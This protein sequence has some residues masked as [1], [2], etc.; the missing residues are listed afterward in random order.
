MESVSVNFI[1]YWRFKDYPHL[2]I[3]KCKKIINSITCKILV[4]HTKGFYIGNRYIKRKD[5]R[6]MIE[7]I[8]K[9]DRLP[10]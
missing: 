2:K 5:L 6:D 7:P 8:P 3:T 1:V 9:E 4:Y 10:F